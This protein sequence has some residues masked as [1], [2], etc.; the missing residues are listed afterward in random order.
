MSNTSHIIVTAVSEGN[1]CYFYV[2]VS[3][4]AEPRY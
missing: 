1:H 3:T 2:C 4:T